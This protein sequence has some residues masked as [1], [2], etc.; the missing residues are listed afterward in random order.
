MNSAPILLLCF[1]VFIRQPQH[2]FWT[3]AS[4]LFVCGQTCVPGIVVFLFQCFISCRNPRLKPRG[5]RVIIRKWKLSGLIINTLFE[6]SPSFDA[7]A[8]SD[9]S[10]TPLL[11]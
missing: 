1:R 3:N 6:I 2:P 9:S 7:D 10:N 4:R 5:R 8:A 11:Q